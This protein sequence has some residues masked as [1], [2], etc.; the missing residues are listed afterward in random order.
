MKQKKGGK[1]LTI[2]ITSCIVFT[3]YFIEG[4]NHIVG[5]ILEDC[6]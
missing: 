3:V 2:L 6:S 1:S 5:K 4:K